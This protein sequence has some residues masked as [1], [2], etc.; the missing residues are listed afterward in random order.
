LGVRS[1]SFRSTKI[2]TESGSDSVAIFTNDTVH[3]KASEPL[4][5][6]LPIYRP[7]D[8]FLCCRLEDVDE[9]AS[10]K[11]GVRNDESNG[12]LLPQ[13]QLARLLTNQTQ[14]NNGIEPMQRAK[15]FGEEGRD[16]IPTPGRML[17]Y[18]IERRN[19]ETRSFQL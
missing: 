5:V 17:A 11:F 19:F 10:D 4:K 3:A 13:F 18:S 16:Y 15:H 1:R 7:N 14:R 9:V 6:S 2:A 8:H 12:K